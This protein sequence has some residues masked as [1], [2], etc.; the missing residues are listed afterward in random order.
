MGP[1]HDT[2]LLTRWLLLQSLCKCPQWPLSIKTCAHMLC[3]RHASPAICQLN[4]SLLRGVSQLAS[5]PQMVMSAENR[6]LC[7]FYRNPPPGSSQAPLAWTAIAKMVWNVNGRTHPTPSAVRKCVLGWWRA[8]KM[9]GRKKGTRKTTKV[10]DRVI[11]AS[12][13]KARLPLGSEVTSRDV[14]IR[15]P[16]GLRGKVSQRTIRR[17]LAEYGFR[18][19]R[20]AEKTDFLKKQRLARMAFCR[21]HEHRSPTGWAAYLQ[22]CGDLKDFTYFP[23]KMK[24]RFT[25]YRCAW[26][27]MKASER[28]RA[29]FLKPKKERM[30]GRKE[31][32]NARKGKILG[33]TTSTGKQLFV[34]CPQPW[35]STAF[36]R[37]VR[38]RVGPFFRN[39]FPGVVNIRILLDSEPL[40]HTEGAKVAFAEFG[41]HAM[42]D[43]PKYSPDLNPQENVWSWVE[44][45]LRRDE[46]SSDTFP[47]FCKRLLRVAKRYPAGSAL[48]PS[49]RQRMLAVI[50][51]KG[52]MTKF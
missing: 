21:A 32:R 19:T 17:R 34:M 33:F 8:R 5:S 44:Q 30:F 52:A 3:L 35:N 50:G 25:R 45:A 24:A 20:K 39:N 51:C 12:F 4:C 27:Y 28:R 14:A 47:V 10:E 41:M 22:G 1:E 48:I 46:R 6:A 29:E 16:H 15:L 9:R 43:W 7:F 40:L 26:T 36:A 37:L 13:L 11:K 38:R 23:R 2:K 49:M 31:Y 42:P 18:P